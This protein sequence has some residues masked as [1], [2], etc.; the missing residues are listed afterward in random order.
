MR[1][2]LNQ[3]FFRSN[4]TLIKWICGFNYTKLI[5]KRIK[6]LL[7]FVC[8][9]RFMLQ[10]VFIISILAWKSRRCSA[11]SINI[12][13]A[14]STAF[15]PHNSITTLNELKIQNW[16]WKY[17]RCIFMR[18]ILQLPRKPISSVFHSL[19]LQ[20]NKWSS[21]NRSILLLSDIYLTYCFRKG[22]TEPR[23]YQPTHIFG[24]KLDDYISCDK[25]TKNTFWPI[26]NRRREEAKRT[27][28]E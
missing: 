9:S 28:I 15:V 3:P 4:S 10:R 24:T 12:N 5:W 8:L 21:E 17:L 13:R 11:T 7:P 14:R 2:S 19:R 25:I 18:L 20:N 22:R 16:N 27:V 1:V 6:K 23:K 26:K